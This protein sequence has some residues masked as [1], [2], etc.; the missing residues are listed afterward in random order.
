MNNKL[1]IYLSE[2]N[3][4]RVQERKREKDF[5]RNIFGNYILFSKLCEQSK[6]ASHIYQYGS[7]AIK[8]ALYFFLFALAFLKRIIIE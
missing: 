5:E 1:F 8:N 2:C 3:C 6:A 7:I 4:E